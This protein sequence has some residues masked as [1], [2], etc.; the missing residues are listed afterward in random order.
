MRDDLIS[1]EQA[2][3][4]LGN[5]RRF[6]DQDRL[7]RDLART[8]IAQAAKRDRIDAAWSERVALLTDETAGLRRQL[9]EAQGEFRKGWRFAYGQWDRTGSVPNPDYTP[10]PETKGAAT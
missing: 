2:Q 4:L 6:G 7:V 10:D 3:A 8:V 5:P 9:A 1:A